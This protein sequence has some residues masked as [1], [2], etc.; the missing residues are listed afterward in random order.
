VTGRGEESA[1]TWLIFGALRGLVGY[2]GS[3]RREKA[4]SKLE[5]A[6]FQDPDGCPA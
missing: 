4:A 6:A 1:T 3:E 5:S 2:I